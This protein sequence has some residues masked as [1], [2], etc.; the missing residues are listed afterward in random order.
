MKKFTLITILVLS[1]MSLLSSGCSRRL[2]AAMANHLNE[3][4]AANK[5]NDDDSSYAARE[6]I[7]QNYTFAPDAKVN[8][9][10]I[11]GSVD[12]TTTEGTKAEIHI[13]RLA[14]NKEAFENHKTTIEFENNELTIEGNRKKNSGI[15]D[16]VTG[17]DDLRIR[18]TLKLP[19]NIDIETSGVNG[20]VNLGEIDG[21]VEARGI[22]GKVTI[23]KASGA[24][25]FSDI[26]GKIEATIA[27]LNKDGISIHGVNGNVDLKFLD[28][29]NA[30]IEAHGLN[31]R[32]NADLPNLQVKDQKHSNYSAVVGSGG[33]TIEVN[34]TNGNIWLS[35][36]KNTVSAT[37]KSEVKGS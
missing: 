19:R 35:S 13:L 29:V 25:E 31:G 8:V 1:G 16:M 27:K 11:N 34:G 22:N 7:S 37:P 2:H 5:G 15:W 30:N 24:T 18:V 32:V 26:N 17:N 6:E 10:G 4:K 23:A 21:R 33:P 28:E 14:R 36:A 12:V 3:N 20:R 9:Y